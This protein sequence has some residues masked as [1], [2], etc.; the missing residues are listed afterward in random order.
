MSDSDEEVNIDLFQEPDGFFKPAPEPTFAIH[1]LLAGKKLKLRLVGHNPLWVGSDP[2]HLV[3]FSVSSPL[4]VPKGLNLVLHVSVSVFR[5]LSPSMSLISS[6][7]YPS[8][9]AFRMEKIVP[10]TDD[11]NISY[12]RSSYH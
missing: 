1:T 4:L 11:I 8:S 3:L 5:S 9:G 10:L 6:P 7:N 12:F 2:T